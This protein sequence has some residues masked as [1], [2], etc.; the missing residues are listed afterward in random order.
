MIRI[1]LEKKFEEFNEKESELEWSGVE[2]TFAEVA[3]DVVG[4][5]VLHAL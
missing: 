2:F 1:D 4:V 5:I 3:V